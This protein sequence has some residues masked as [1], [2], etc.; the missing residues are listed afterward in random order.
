MRGDADADRFADFDA[1]AVFGGIDAED[2]AHGPVAVLNLDNLGAV[3]CVKR[4]DV[5]LVRQA[6]C[7]LGLRLAGLDDLARLLA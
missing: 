1:A 3:G 7:D 6:K 2:H 5:I 4:G